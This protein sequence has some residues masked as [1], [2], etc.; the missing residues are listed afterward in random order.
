MHSQPPTSMC[1]K[2]CSNRQV[3]PAS[4]EPGGTGTEPGAKFA[5]SDCSDVSWV[6]PSK[7]LAFSSSSSSWSQ[8]S[9][10][11]WCLC[12]YAQGVRAARADAAR[13]GTCRMFPS[14]KLSIHVSS[15]V[16][17]CS[18]ALAVRVRLLHPQV[19][20]CAAL[21]CTA[22]S[23]AHAAARAMQCP[24]PAGPLTPGAPPIERH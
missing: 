19:T 16:R 1:W 7:G 12:F 6:A 18:G 22:L 24:L 9:S 5:V 14:S 4:Q 2:S 8:A 3:T 15:R 20:Y 11:S 23:Q 21:S 17:G 10:S 13:M